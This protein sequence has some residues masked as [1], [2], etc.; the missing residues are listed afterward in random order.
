MTW[1]RREP[2]HQQPGYWI[3]IITWSYALCCL[4]FSSWW[5]HVYN[6][7]IFS[8]VASQALGQ[9]YD[10]PSARAVTLKD[11]GKLDQWQTTTKHNKAMCRVLWM[12]WSSLQV[13]SGALFHPLF[14]VLQAPSKPQTIHNIS[15][16]PSC[17]THEGWLEILW[18]VHLVLRLAMWAVLGTKVA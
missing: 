17:R 3:E 10:L 8:R 6:L 14:I 1:H 4:Y 15:S 18:I 13:L 11:M 12:Y 16:H 2:R 5:N 7:P 9:L